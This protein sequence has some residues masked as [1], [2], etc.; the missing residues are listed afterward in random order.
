MVGAND[1]SQLQGIVW[2][3]SDFECVLSVTFDDNDKLTH[4]DFCTVAD[5]NMPKVYRSESKFDITDITFN[6]DKTVSYAKLKP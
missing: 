6:A 2:E 4:L 1:E 5:F 3:F